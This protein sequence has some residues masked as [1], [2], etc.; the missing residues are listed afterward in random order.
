MKK[1]RLWI[2]ILVSLVGLY[3]AARGVDVRG[4]LDALGQMQ[5]AW[6]FPAFGLILLGLLARALRWR[7]L[8]QP[9]SGAGIRIGR[10]FNLLNIGYLVNLV[11]PVR[12][13]DLLR[14]YLCS[15][16][17]RLS[18]V[19]AL[20]TVAVERIVDTLT[21]VF[22]LVLIVPF[23]TLPSSLAQP[24]FAIGLVALV[25]ALVLVL[26]VSRRERSVALFERVAGRIHFLN[27]PQVRHSVLAALDGLTVLRSLRSLAGVAVLSLIAWLCVAAEFQVVMHAMG[28]RLPPVAAMLVLCLTTLGMAVPSSPGYLGV[29]EYLTVVALDVFGISR[30]IALGY[31][32]VLHGIAYLGFL[33][34]G[35]AAVWMEGYSYNRLRTVLAQVTPSSDST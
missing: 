23:V 4:L 14:A 34:L 20:S 3:L 7:L 35:G 19:G 26:V 18:V 21:I 24:A 30:D 9:V 16:L 27:R 29:F 5:P 17:Q 25:A 13:G 2:S 31:A 15:E 11:S 33:L 12:L 28:L 6:L 8:L 32:L 1:W 22:L 10:L